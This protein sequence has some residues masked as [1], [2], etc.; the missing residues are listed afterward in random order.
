[1][2][3][4]VVSNAGTGAVLIA[5]SIP[6][7]VMSGDFRGGTRPTLTGNLAGVETATIVRFDSDGTPQ[8]VRNGVI[9]RANEGSVALE[10]PGEY[11]V[12]KDATVAN[13]DL[14]LENGI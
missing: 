5:D 2:K 11:G 4:T 8:P 12:F 9:D 6:F 7:T 13:F 14:V 1:M 3:R 10:S